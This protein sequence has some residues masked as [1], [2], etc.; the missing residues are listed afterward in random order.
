MPYHHLSYRK[1]RTLCTDKATNGKQSEDS[2][3]KKKGVCAD[4]SVDYRS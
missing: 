4:E 3:K 2:I 1:E